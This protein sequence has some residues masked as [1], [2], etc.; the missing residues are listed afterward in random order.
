MILNNEN[1]K[2]EA[3]P[4]LDTIKQRKDEKNHRKMWIIEN[5]LLCFIFILPLLGLILGHYFSEKY[6][7]VI[8]LL[9][10]IVFVVSILCFIRFKKKLIPYQYIHR[11]H[12]AMLIHTV[13]F[14]KI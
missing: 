8:L 11:K 4:E 3:F 12:T 2:V 14:G 13:A 7:L 10:A 1:I 9:T 5:C 6:R